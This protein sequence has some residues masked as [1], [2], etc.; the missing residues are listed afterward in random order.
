[1][2]VSTFFSQ[3]S[4]VI[5]RGT[6]LDADIPAAFA[7]AL[8]FIEQNYSLAYMRR[9][10]TLAVS[11]LVRSFTWSGLNAA[12]LKSIHQIRW[13]DDDSRWNRL[14]KVEE[15]DFVD[16]SGPIPSGYIVNKEIAMDGTESQVFEMD[17][18]F[19]EATELNITAYHFTKWT[20]DTAAANIWLLNNAQQLMLARTMINIAPIMRD[21]DLLSMYQASWQE[22]V[23]TLIQWQDEEEQANRVR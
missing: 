3:V 23:A 15:L 20:G 14:I 4:S 2:L 10:S 21:G 8:Q 12:S 19:S 18:Y 17:S 9:V 6:T 7:G 16:T 5:R 13:L 22:H 11:P 1:M